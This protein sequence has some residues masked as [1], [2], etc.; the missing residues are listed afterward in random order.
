MTDHNL[1]DGVAEP[2]VPRRS[3]GAVVSEALR[4]APNLIKLIWRCM[5]DRRVPIRAK[6]VA[7]AAAGYFVSPV[8]LVP[9][10]IPV[11]GQLDD[12]LMLFLGIHHLI[13][14]TPPEVIAELWDGEEDALELV[15]GFLAWMAELVPGPLHRIAS[16]G[17]G[18]VESPA[19]AS[20]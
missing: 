10:F 20:S 18:S 5:T 14:A 13:R 7:A 6:V 2:V 3:T 12:L 15:T 16:G 11:V 9:D 8:D 17:T 4:V 19:S 1:I